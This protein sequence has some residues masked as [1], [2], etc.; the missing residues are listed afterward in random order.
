MI[1]FLI[2]FLID[3]FWGEK[4][5]KSSGLAATLFYV[6]IARYLFKCR[7]LQTQQCDLKRTASLDSL[8]G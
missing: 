5:D 3:T 2:D 7:T 8:M 4:G 6:I 1:Q